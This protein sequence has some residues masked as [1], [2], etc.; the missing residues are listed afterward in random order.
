[1]NATE[2]LKDVRP[3]DLIKLIEVWTN[4]AKTL[5]FL[6]R[7]YPSH[8]FDEILQDEGFDEECRPNIDGIICMDKEDYDRG[9]YIREDADL[10]SQLCAVIHE[11]L[12]AERPDW[13]EPM[14]HAATLCEMERISCAAHTGAGLDPAAA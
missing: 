11:T 5:G 13:D 4:R 7:F 1:M 8:D 2:Q 3:E 10:A 6:V 12:H 9:I 14:V